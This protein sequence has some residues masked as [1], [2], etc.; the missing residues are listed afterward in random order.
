MLEIYKYFLLDNYSLRIDGVWYK[1]FYRFILGQ[2][3]SLT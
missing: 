1:K 2:D 3:Q